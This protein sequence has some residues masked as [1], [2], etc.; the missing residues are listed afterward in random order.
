MGETLVDDDRG[1]SRER[2]HCQLIPSQHCEIPSDHDIVS[3]ILRPTFDSR[4]D[5][6][7]ELRM[8]GDKSGE[9]RMPVSRSSNQRIRSKADVG[10]PGKA[11]D[12]AIADRL[13]QD[14]LGGFLLIR[15]LSRNVEL[16]DRPPS[17]GTCSSPFPVCR[18]TR[19]ALGRS[20]RFSS[21]QYE[22]S[23]FVIPIALALNRIDFGKRQA[24]S[25]AG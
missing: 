14:P 3:G 18:S 17:R 1:R 8:S 16:P 25:R 2:L 12:H 24:L 5:R 23:Q 21:R 19:R 10:E 20:S 13:A 6:A 9:G 22:H 11:S 4:C 7:D 15:L